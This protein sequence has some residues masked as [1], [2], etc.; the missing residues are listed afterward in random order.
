MIKPL[1]FAFFGGEP[2]AVPVLEKLSTAGLTPSLVV[3]NPD[4]PSGRGQQLTPP[5]AKAWAAQHGIPVY[6]PTTHKDGDSE[7]RLSSEA[8]DLFV[9]VA[10]NFI[11]PDWLLALPQHGVLNLH[12]SLLPLL[13]GASPIRSAILQD[14]PEALGVTIMLID[15]EMDHGPILAQTPFPIEPDTWPIDGP[16]LDAQLATLGGE[17]LAQTIPAWMAGDIT[18][19]AQQHAAATYCHKLQKSDAEV[20]I[21][22]FD[23]PA[24]AAGW[25]IWL[26]INAFAGIGDAFFLHD[27]KRVKIKKAEFTDGKLRLL[28]VTPEGKKEVTFT[29]YLRS[30]A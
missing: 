30:L 10:Y 5:P 1:K 27:G 17:L 13:R 16:T 22:P 20:A 29:E 12:P 28:R 4:R 23:L 2:L 6:Q 14:R 18:P 19:Q 11:L 21:N 24:G 8:W 7:T 3:C 25:Q 26:T 15:T 9:V